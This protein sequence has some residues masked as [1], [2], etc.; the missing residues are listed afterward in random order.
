MEEV[1]KE[2]TDV[3]YHFGTLHTQFTKQ[4]GGREWIHSMLKTL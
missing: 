4:V 3:V 1:D 2:K